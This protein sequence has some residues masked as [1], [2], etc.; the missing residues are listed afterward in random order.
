MKLR[1]RDG[2][3]FELTVEGYQFPEISDDRWDSNWLII[4]GRVEHPRGGWTFRDPCLTTFELDRLA[5]WFEGVAR[6]DPRRDAVYFTEPNLDFRYVREP[7]AAIEVRLGYESGPPWAKSGTERPGSTTLCF[8]LAESPPQQA[9]QGL[10]AELSRFPARGPND[11][12]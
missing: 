4:C 6:S 9:A 11:A 12:A 5:G 10:R 1:A 2:T 7:E 8:P 3:A